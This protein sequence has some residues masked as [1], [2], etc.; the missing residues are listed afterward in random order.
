MRNRLR[1]FP[2][3]VSCTSI[4]WYSKWPNTALTEVAARL[5]KDTELA[6]LSALSNGTANGGAAEH[7]KSSA[8]MV[9]TNNKLKEQLASLF[10]SFHT[11][12]LEMAQKMSLEVKRQHWITPTKYLDLIQGYKQLLTQRAAYIDGQAGKLRAGLEKLESSG[13]QVAVMTVQLEE[14]KRVVAAKKLTCD[15]L[16]IE[17]VQKQ[18][19]ADEQKKQ[20]ELDAARTEVEAKECES[21]KHE[22]QDELDKVLPAL[23][24]AVKA[25]ERLS[26]SAVTEVKSYQKPPK[27]V[28]RV[29][30]AVMTVMDKEPSWATAKKELNGRQFPLQAQGVRQGQ[31]QQHDTESHTEVYQESRLQSG[32]YW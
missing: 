19:A 11:S 28:E 26:K 4:D 32:G 31:N 3:L 20:V 24:K 17:I 14:K 6:G 13:E 8:G 7:T 10:T 27:P 5:L 16:L 22:A 12:A 15:K 23:D 25:L 18:R 30:C 21:I 1:M 2:A 9:A 29:M